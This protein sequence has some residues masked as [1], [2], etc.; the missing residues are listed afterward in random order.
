MRPL[1]FLLTLLTCVSAFFCL[2]FV[3]PWRTSTPEDLE[4]RTKIGALFNWRAPSSLFPPSAIISLTD[5][6]ST[7]FLARPAAFGPLLPSKSLSGQLWIG[8]GFGDDHLGRGGA[9]GGAE[10]EL[11][12]SDIPDWDDDGYRSNS[13]PAGNVKKPT[14]ADIQSLQETAEIAGKVVLLSRG[15]CGFLEKVKW[16][17]RRG[18]VALIV[19]DD[20]RGGPLVTMYAHGDT[21][22]VTIP[23]LFTS[24]MTAHLLS[25]LIPSG[26]LA[27]DLSAEEAA[28]LGLV[29][30]DK[31]SAGKGAKKSGVAEKPNF[32][33]TAAA[34]KATS[35]SKAAQSKAKVNIDED[36]E[37]ERSREA[38]GWL[39]SVFTRGGSA[40]RADSRR[41]P[42]SGNLD[43]VQQHDFEDGN[44][45][46]GVIG[47][48]A[49]NPPTK[50]STKKVPSTGKG[51]GF[52][53]G[54]QDWRDPDMVA[55]EKER[56]QASI[57]SATSTSSAAAQSSASPKHAGMHGGSITPGSGEY[58]KANHDVAS[59]SGSDKQASTAARSGKH[60][61]ADDVKSGNWFTRFFHLEAERERSKATPDA[62]TKASEPVSQSP[63]SEGSH[64]DDQ[65]T[66]RV[67]QHD[68]LWVTLTP[69]AVSSSPFFDTL[70]VLVVSPL[71]TLTV[72]Y[73]LLL[74]RSRIRR[75]RWRAPKS[76][77]QRL[78][79]RT[80]HTMSSSATSAS[81]PELSSPVSATTPLLPSS[82]RPINA[83]ARPRSRTASE[84]P[85]QA[86]SSLTESLAPPSLE[87]IE[88]KRAAGLAEW[89][90]RYGGDVV[91]S[92]ARLNT[93]NN[94]NNNN[95]ATATSPLLP[96]SSLPPPQYHDDPTEETLEEQVQEQAATTR[97]DDPAAALPVSRE[98]EAF[99]DLE[100]GIG[101]ERSL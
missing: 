57:S 2:L 85:V 92:L 43:W 54:V 26:S 64:A 35:T 16:V 84:V 39:R 79:V 20:L 24:H 62:A 82:P 36:E 17:Q 89:R 29:F 40:G 8:S 33:T 61:K 51:D 52:V 14:H 10:G 63:H 23:A 77:V 95:T 32:T 81:T 21:S 45:D 88:E 60:S 59:L 7:F 9:G 13:E 74:L 37:E 90:R 96:P 50:P 27:E 86:S 70:L 67:P 72:V 5:D 34:A 31:G 11:G 68:G 28:R 22:N 30:G 53:I 100:R 78:P 56:Q 49:G 98:D 80:Y 73:A 69:T 18:G 1:R 91:R 94:N 3:G 42:S 41:P 12:C 58:V 101:G 44:D 6:N 48:K 75:R 83:R 47:R 66:N 93:G 4:E 71:V 76:V 38:A 87:Q 15:G 55:D 25:S 46:N 97:N 65:S 19:G 99:E